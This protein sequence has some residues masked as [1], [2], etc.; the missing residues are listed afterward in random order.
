MSPL[1]WSVTLPRIEA[2]DGEKVWNGK[3]YS[4]ALYPGKRCFIICRLSDTPFPAFIDSKRNLFSAPNMVRDAISDYLLAC[5]ED[6]GV[7]DFVLDGRL[8]YRDGPHGYTRFQN[9]A[10]DEVPKQTVF[11]ADDFY[12]YSEFM[13]GQGKRS[14]LKRRKR[15]RGV[16]TEIDSDRIRMTKYK[17]LKSKKMFK[18]MRGEAASVRD[19][20]LVMRKDVPYQCGRSGNILSIFPEGE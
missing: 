3:W 12:S 6:G 19:F 15:L 14:F 2:Y 4:A 11:Y 13:K 1:K 20:G 7:K 9:Y 10:N 17:C 5:R 8:G 16:V 18:E